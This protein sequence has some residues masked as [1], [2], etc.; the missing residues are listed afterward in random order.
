MWFAILACAGGAVCVLGSWRVT[1]SQ[2]SADALEAGIRA[3]GKGASTAFASEVGVSVQVRELGERIRTAGS[4]SAGIAELNEFISEVDRDNGAQ[5][6]L[7]LARV[8]FTLGVLLGVLALAAPLRSGGDVGLQT[9][10][11][12]LIAVTAGLASG[13]VCYRLGLVAKRRRQEF[14]GVL[15]RLVRLLELQLPVSD[16]PAK[17]IHSAGGR[18]RA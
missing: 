17:P 8:C 18:G 9:V 6:P 1:R 16:A 11:P 10:T 12:A 15:R 2:P 13:M 5:V 14:R 3:L 4:R 7:T